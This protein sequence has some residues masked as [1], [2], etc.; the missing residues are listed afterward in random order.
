MGSYITCILLFLCQ[1]VGK[2]PAAL[3]IILH[4]I[5]KYGKKAAHSRELGLKYT[6]EGYER[7]RTEHCGFWTV[8]SSLQQDRQQHYLKVKRI[9]NPVCYPT[10]HFLQLCMGWEVATVIIFVSETL[11]IWVLWWIPTP[12]EI[13]S[14]RTN[15]NMFS[16]VQD[17]NSVYFPKGRRLVYCLP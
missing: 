16:K 17:D 4:C 11:T 8:R 13:S 15:T 1:T 14:P 5:L 6:E 12:L 7:N 9:K 10:S 3:S 2:S